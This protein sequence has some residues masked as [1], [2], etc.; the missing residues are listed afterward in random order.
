MC[1][2]RRGR[3]TEPGDSYLRSHLVM[4]AEALLPASETKTNRVSRWAVALAERRDYWIAVVAIAS[5]N[6]RMASAVLRK[7]EDFALRACK[8]SLMTGMNP[9]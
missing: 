4:G 8:P 7:G 6:A 5:K 2:A 3:I 1:S 9:L